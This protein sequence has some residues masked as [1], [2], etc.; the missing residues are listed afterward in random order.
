M[1]KYY[2]AILCVIVAGPCH[3]I[4]TFVRDKEYFFITWFCSIPKATKLD[5][6]TDI[7][8]VR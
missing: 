1:L 3:L 2:K 6:K 4:R 7:Q 5:R 8:T